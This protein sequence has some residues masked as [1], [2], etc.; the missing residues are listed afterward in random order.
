MC[1]EDRQ[2]RSERHKSADVMPNNTKIKMSW[3]YMFWKVILEGALLRTA[4]SWEERFPWLELTSAAR[5]YWRILISLSTG[6]KRMAAY[7]AIVTSMHNH[8]PLSCSYL[9]CQPPAAQ[10]GC[11]R[12]KRAAVPRSPEPWT[13]RSSRNTQL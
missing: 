2:I 13:A 10:L 8:I 11:P 7:K 6:H 3:S 4:W 9:T 5:M 1:I 12:P